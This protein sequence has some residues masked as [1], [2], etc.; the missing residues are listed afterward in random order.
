M[1]TDHQR[2]RER[3]YGRKQPLLQARYQQAGGGL[4]ASGFATQAPFAQLTVFVQK[5]CKRQLRSVRRQSVIHALEG[6][7]EILKD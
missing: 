2:T 3:L 6:V 5:G 1:G 7:L 4:L